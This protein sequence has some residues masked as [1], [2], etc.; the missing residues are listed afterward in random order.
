MLTLKF[1]GGQ[2]CLNN[3]NVNQRGQRTI[4]DGRQVIVPKARFNCNGRITN[5][6]VSMEKW[7][8]TTNNPLFQVW[9]PTSLNSSTYNKLTEVQLPAGIFKSIGRNQNYYKVSLSLNSS[10]QIEFQSG[11]VIGYYQPSNTQRH[12]WSIQTSGYT[13]YSYTAKSSTIDINSA[14][15]IDT[16]LQPLIKV[17]FGKIINKLNLYSCITQLSLFNQPIATNLSYMHMH[18]H[19]LLIFCAIRCPP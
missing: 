16:N 8:G 15:N 17:I 5:V 7:I 2:T 12:I 14:E 3:P 10:S 9:H 19:I 6:A 4:D 18:S 1:S 13:S 11:D